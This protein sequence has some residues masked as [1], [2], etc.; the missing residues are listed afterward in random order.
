MES[1]SLTRMENLS[2]EPG[3]FSPQIDFDGNT[4][5]LEIKGASFM[6]H[7]LDFY[8]PVLSWLDQFA[9]QSHPNSTLKIY[10]SYFNSGSSGML[11]DIL[12]LLEEKSEL[13]PVL[14]EWYVDPNDE[15][16]LA[17]GEEFKDCFEKLNFKIIQN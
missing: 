11:Y 16:M 14:V 12:Q 13:N 9:Q 5:N 6:E 4:G 1:I 3:K 7:P 17:E 2:I 8:D 10:L 15:E